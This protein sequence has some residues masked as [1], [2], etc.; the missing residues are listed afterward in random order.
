MSYVHVLQLFLGDHRT[1]GTSNPSRE[2]FRSYLRSILGIL[3][4]PSS[5]CREAGWM[6]L[7][8]LTGEPLDF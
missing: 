2:C 7:R 8:A 4:P 3:T 5:S 1:D 6:W